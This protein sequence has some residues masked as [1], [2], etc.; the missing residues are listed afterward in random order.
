MIIKHS[1]KRAKKK[2]IE[3][4]GLIIAITQIDNSDYISL[5]DIARSKNA[6]EP[7]DVV[8]N[9]L[10]SKSVLEFL[11]L[12]EQINNPNFKGVDFDSL[13]SEAGSNSF[14]LSPTKWIETTRA[15][16]IFTKVGNNGGTYAH[17]RYSFR[18]CLLDFSR[19]QTVPHQ[20]I[21]A[22]QRRR[23]RPIE[24]SMEFSTHISKGQ[25]SNSH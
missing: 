9:W 19:L 13:M 5:T 4:Q 25:L 23:K 17:Q 12:G 7:K 8:K 22:P 16:G 10:R 11:G 3:V 1:I 6:S 18:I 24:P 21:P 15:I 14:T 20:R 2:N